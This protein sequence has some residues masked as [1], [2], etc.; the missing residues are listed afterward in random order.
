MSIVTVVQ[1]EEHQLGYLIET[2]PGS[3]LFLFVGEQTTHTGKHI[4]VTE[5]SAHQSFRFYGVLAPSYAEAIA[6]KYPRWC[7]RRATLVA[8]VLDGHVPQGSI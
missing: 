8:Q 3:G 1:Q 2:E 4:H 6:K 7:W 5:T